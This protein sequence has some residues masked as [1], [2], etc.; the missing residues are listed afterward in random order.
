[1]N[2]CPSYSERCSLP[3]QVRSA[4]TKGIFTTGQ[5]SIGDQITPLE[6]G[7]F[8]AAPVSVRTG[9]QRQSRANTRID[10][11]VAERVLQCRE[12]WL[13]ATVARG[14][15]LHLEG[16]FDRRNSLRNSVIRR[17]D[18][19]EAAGDHAN[20]RIDGGRRF[21]DL[22]DPRMGAA[23]DEYNAIRRVDDQG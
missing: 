1:M 11:P 13:A 18:E 17:H 10:I 9:S 3:W 19:V 7:A 8:A 21:E 22:L 20:L 14:D 12:R 23:D 4:D 15:V 5:P 16:V 6:G 2:I